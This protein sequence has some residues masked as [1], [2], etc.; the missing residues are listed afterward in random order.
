MSEPIS[1]VHKLSPRL[2]ADSPDTRGREIVVIELEHGTRLV[3]GTLLNDRP[4]ESLV[5]VDEDLRNA[6]SISMSSYH[7]TI[8]EDIPLHAHQEKHG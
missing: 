1:Q 7:V 6:A 4:R 3:G 8:R 5:T 2:T